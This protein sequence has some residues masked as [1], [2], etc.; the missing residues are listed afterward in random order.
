M[1]TYLIDHVDLYEP[2]SVQAE[3]KGKAKY[4][5]FQEW[6]TVFGKNKREDFSVF[7]K[8]ILLVKTIK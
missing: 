5:L 8:G 7:L 3:T 2:I 6:Y 1:T 4:L